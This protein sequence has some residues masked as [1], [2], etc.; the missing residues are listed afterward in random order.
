MLKVA[1]TDW[2]AFIVTVQ[3][4]VPLQAPDQPAKKVPLP[5]VAVSLTL[6]PEL[7]DALHVGAQL[8]PAGLLVTVPV[9]VP[10]N[11]TESWKVVAGAEETPA[12]PDCDAAADP[13]AGSATAKVVVK[14]Q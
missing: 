10:A 11:W 3:V 14:T 9:E 7:N 5:G 1:V 8:I 6:V 4:P 12:R 2:F 13:V